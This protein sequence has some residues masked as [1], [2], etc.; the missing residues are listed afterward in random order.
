MNIIVATL[1]AIILRFVCPGI[2]SFVELPVR[3]QVASTQC[4]SLLASRISQTGRMTP[5]DDNI[6]AEVRELRHII[7]TSASMPGGLFHSEPLTPSRQ[8]HRGVVLLDH[9]V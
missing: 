3:G 1:F 9:S 5:R 8:H 7:Q 2:S 4:T 6:S